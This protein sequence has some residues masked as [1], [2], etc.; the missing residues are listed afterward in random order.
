MHQT[1]RIPPR[2]VPT[3]TEVVQVPAPGS[4]SA[5]LG[6]SVRVAY[7]PDDVVDKLMHRLDGPLQLAIGNILSSLAIDH[8][9]KLE[10]LLRDE[11]DRAVRRA[12]DDAL[13][14]ELDAQSLAG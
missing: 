7:N 11:I 14:A 8:F 1:T 9:K 13:A 2:F 6:D 4:T 10:P 12:V 5:I 3:L